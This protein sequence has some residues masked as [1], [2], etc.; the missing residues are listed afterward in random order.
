[1]GTKNLKNSP[2]ARNGPAPPP[3]WG[4]P[5]KLLFCRKP[6]PTGFAPVSPPRLLRPGPRLG[7]FGAPRSGRGK[8]RGF[9]PGPRPSMVPDASQPGDRLRRLAYQAVFRTRRHKSAAGDP[10]PNPARTVLKRAATVDP[11]AS[12]SF[13]VG[14]QRKCTATDSRHFGPV[15]LGPPSE[16]RRSTATQPPGKG[17]GRLRPKD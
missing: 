17:T 8:T 14:E 6:G 1:L 11:E 2:K 3:R 5:E 12:G 9:V 10:R 4:R 15:P 13:L 16:E 7:P